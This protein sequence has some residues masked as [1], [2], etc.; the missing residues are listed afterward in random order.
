MAR[1]FL[2]QPFEHPLVRQLA[3]ALRE[4]CEKTGQTL[5]PDFI[6][7]V[8]KMIYAEIAIAA[9]GGRGPDNEVVT[10]T[11]NIDEGLVRPMRPEG[12]LEV[13]VPWKWLLGSQ[14]SPVDLRRRR[15]G[16]R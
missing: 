13:A 7:D 4:Q 14:L 1:Q 9:Y 11:M 10:L 12:W 2:N 16:L 15:Q 8:P 6:V 5:P 3:A